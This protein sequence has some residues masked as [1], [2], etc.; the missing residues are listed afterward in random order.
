MS[1]WFIFW[2][3]VLSCVAGCGIAYIAFRVYVMQF[4]VELALAYQEDME[5]L[6][7]QLKADFLE[8]LKK[9]K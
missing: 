6:L 2:N 1:F 4:M 5:T 7:A 8:D 3:I 9:L